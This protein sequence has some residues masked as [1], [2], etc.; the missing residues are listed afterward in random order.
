[1]EA[2]EAA[3]NGSSRSLG[4]PPTTNLTSTTYLQTYVIMKPTGTEEFG[5]NNAYR[6][7]L[8]R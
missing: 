7:V 2:A 1:M 5:T 4:R 8:F 6:D 3:A